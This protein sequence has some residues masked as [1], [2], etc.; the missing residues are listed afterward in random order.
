LLGVLA[1]CTGGPVGQANPLPDIK[2]TTAAA[3]DWQARE[4]AAS[5]V[6]A[7]DGWLLSIRSLAKGPASVLLLEAEFPSQFT[8]TQVQ[9]LVPQS[10]L[11][12]LVSDH[13][14]VLALGVYMPTGRSIQ[15]GEILRAKLS[16]SNGALRQ[17]SKLPQG[18]AGEV[19]DLVG[20][21]NETGGFD[22]S[23]GYYSTGDY[24]QNGEVNIA[25]L[26]PIAG[27]FKQS[28][29]DGDRDALDRLLDG[30]GNT[31]INLADITP[32]ASNFHNLVAAYRVF[33][34]DGPDP[35]TATSTLVVEIT[36]DSSTVPTDSRRLFS[37][38]VQGAD[39]VAGTYYFVRPYDTGTGDVGPP[40]N[41]VQY[42]A[43]AAMKFRLP[44][45]GESIVDG[46]QCQ[47]PSLVMLPGVPGLS[48]DGAPVLVYTSLGGGG[49]PLMLG[50]YG[51]DGWASEDIS[52][53]H[54]FA[55]PKATLLPSGGAAPGEGMIVAYDI[56]GLTVVDRRFDELWVQTSGQDVG[57]G[58]GAFSRL[59]FDRDPQSGGFGV[60]HAYT[61]TGT[62][63]VQYSYAGATGGWTTEP[64]W[65]GDMVG[66]LAFRFDP[67][68]GAPW[69][70]FTHGTFVTSPT[71]SIKFSLEQA[72]RNT[73]TWSISP[74]PYPDS[75][76]F[77]DLGFRPDGTPQ[78]VCT[79]AR[80]YTISI[81]L[82]DPITISLLFDVATAE[83]GGTSWSFKRAYES[84][85][86]FSLGGGFPPTTLVLNLDFASEAGWAQPDEL[87]YSRAAGTVD[88]DLQT[89]LPTGAA[90][91]GTSQ[92]MQR[93]GSEVY[94]E[95]GYY[96][97]S[98]GR[99]YSWAPNSQGQPTCAHVR[100]TSISAQD[101]LNGNFAAAGELAFWRP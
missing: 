49:T 61:G 91:S 88:I 1:S 35:L 31:E 86:G 97:G 96:D 25:D 67:G 7:A 64:V 13:P 70:L 26:T 65:S 80:D 73:S 17:S 100:G 48:E 9:R 40:S 69:L 47:N 16:R 43:V 101:V 79:A 6:P 55:M 4:L 27:R 34:A 56:N 78:L 19:P 75:P 93:G 46:G 39:L 82:L 94:G 58:S 28:T 11:D 10:E 63:S 12:L 14:G 68:G 33:R 5:L 71:L 21:E 45:P 90:L 2:L 92:Y 37:A 18:I 20:A 54:N 74:V 23:W 62:G 84:T 95:S 72:R 24:D 36:F 53:G 60:A 15:P 76:L 30:D 38:V 44:P 32:I 57:G 59:A 81:P 29:V 51:K 98:P 50:Y 41:V 87:L 77:V 52:G 89:Q 99:A 8:A 66:G 3:S 85:F 22:L 83:Y 42:M